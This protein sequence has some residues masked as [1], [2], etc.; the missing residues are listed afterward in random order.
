M[1]S[2]KAAASGSY[3]YDSRKAAASG[4]YQYDSSKVMG[5]L[6]RDRNTVPA[7]KDPSSAYPARGHIRALERV[8]TRSR[9]PIDHDEDRIALLT[10]SLVDPA[11][12]RMEKA[13]AL[14]PGMCNTWVGVKT[15]F[16]KVFARPEDKE[17]LEDR[18]D[19]L[20]RRKGR[21]VRDVCTEAL[22]LYDDLEG[23]VTESTV[24]RKLLLALRD[25]DLFSVRI[26]RAERMKNPDVSLSEIVNILT[27]VGETHMAGDAGT[28]SGSA[29][30]SQSGPPGDGPVPMELGNI[31]VATG[32]GLNA[33]SHGSRAPGVTD[34]VSS[35]LAELE[36][37]MSRLLDRFDQPR[38][39]A[40][41][42]GTTRDPR[43][44][45]GHQSG[46][47]GDSTWHDPRDSRLC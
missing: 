45:N 39:D 2:R 31:S 11:A 38:V 5:K 37:A 46:S 21:S 12:L 9:M 23:A 44:Y 40:R 28:A 41:G 19:Q 25:T 34:D 36:R 6:L 29:D 35:R 47:Q 43:Q 22:Q 3:Q 17:E 24:V 16:L 15:L 10:S 7:F 13:M 14:K 18:L 20:E 8:F 30:A 27:Q 32:S 33:V 42:S 4:S 1:Q 26:A